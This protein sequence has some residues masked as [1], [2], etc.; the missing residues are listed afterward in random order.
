MVLAAVLGLALG[1]PALAQQDKALDARLDR[2]EKLVR[3]LREIVVQARQSGDPV[4]VRIVG[5][6]DPDMAAAKRRIYDLDAAIQTLN[7]QVDGLTRD[8]QVSRRAAG[9]L[10]S[11][12]EGVARAAQANE[13]RLDDLMRRVQALEAAAQPVVAAP[14]TPPLADA[15]PAPELAD[16][17]GEA[18]AQAKRLLLAES[19]PAAA[20]A[21][22]QF[23]ERFP[24]DERTAE[25][26]YWLGEALFVQ[27]AYADAATAYIGA[28]R[29]WPKTPWAPNAVVKLARSLIALEKPKD[30]CRT[31]GEFK[32]RYPNAPQPVA[33]R[34]AAARAEA[35]CA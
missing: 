14:P 19:Y 2:I 6:P 11:A 23:I 28:I 24:E 34:A 33:S 12:G 21:F 22:Q 13:A 18:F 25:A 7:N 31:L 10:R 3:Q 17:P 27:T 4:Q 26:R 30:A 16:D 8:V 29:G 1:G 32:K 35:K 9:E 5:D 15:G 20:S